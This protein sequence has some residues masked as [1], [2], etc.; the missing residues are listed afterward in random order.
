M[1]TCMHGQWKFYRLSVKCMLDLLNVHAYIESKK[2]SV[3]LY[4]RMKCMFHVSRG[5]IFNCTN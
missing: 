5:Y 2:M 1:Y 3:E 4:S